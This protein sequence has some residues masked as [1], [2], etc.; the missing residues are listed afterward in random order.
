M[1]FQFCSVSNLPTD[2][3]GTCHLNSL[4]LV[5]SSLKLDKPVQF[6][7]LKVMDLHLLHQEL[8][9]EQLLNHVPVLETLS[10]A[11]NALIIDA[12]GDRLTFPNLE[13][14]SIT[15]KNLLSGHR[16]IARTQAPRL[17][18]LTLGPGGIQA[19]SLRP[20]SWKYGAPMLFESLNHFAWMGA[21][22]IGGDMKWPPMGRDSFYPDA[23]KQ[24]PN[25][26]SHILN[27][28]SGRSLG[29]FVRLSEEL[30][31]QAI[32][33]SLQNLTI[34]YIDIYIDTPVPCS[35]LKL[36]KLRKEAGLP[37][38]RRLSMHFRNT[39]VPRQGAT[40][41]KLESVGAWIG[42]I[43]SSVDW[44]EL[45]GEETEQEVYFPEELDVEDSESLA[46]A[47][48]MEA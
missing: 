38:I 48:D 41:E 7:A 45:E 32:L 35:L 11:G 16:V 15:S 8:S 21:A 33:P 12:E 37:P 27:D 39:G 43:K 34:S 29:A 3:T 2:P 44:F 22:T 20:T 30:G 25:V 24:L 10:I 23:I 28:P 18:S 26:T 17:R 4:K 46:E 47:E 5:S 6:P 13:S 9:C 42:S 36:I 19:A 31:A 1:E 14:L 40:K